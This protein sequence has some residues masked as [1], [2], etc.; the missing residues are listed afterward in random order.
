MINLYDLGVNLASKGHNECIKH[1]QMLCKFVP[2]KHP[3]TKHLARPRA[4]KQ[5]YSPKF[6]YLNKIDELHE[7]M[8][9][10]R[11]KGLP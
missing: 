2:N 10:I 11:L 5:S 8:H 3:Q 6:Y 7:G 1:A 9:D 4:K